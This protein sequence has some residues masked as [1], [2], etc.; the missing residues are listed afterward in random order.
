MKL[1]HLNFNL[2]SSGCY[3]HHSYLVA[4]VQK[5]FFYNIVFSDK[6]FQKKLNQQGFSDTF[7][8]CFDQSIFGLVCLVYSVA[9]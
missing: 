3:S 4:T 6:V 9:P 7:Q 5:S 2:L 8:G 1:S